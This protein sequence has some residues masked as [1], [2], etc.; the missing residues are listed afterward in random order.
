M[1]RPR[2]RRSNL[3]LLLNKMSKN[4]PER[5]RRSTGFSR[6]EVSSDLGE[7]E[8]VGTVEPTYRH[9]EK[10]QKDVTWTTSW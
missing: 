8:K 7:K 10:S 5:R 2:L 4:T 3:L 6:L 1:L 9:E